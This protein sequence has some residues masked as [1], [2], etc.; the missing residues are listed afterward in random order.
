MKQGVLF[1]I[2]ITAL[3]VFTGVQAQNQE[4]VLMTIGDKP[5]Y[6]SEF[7]RILNKNKSNLASQ[8]TDLKESFELFTNFKLKVRE[9]ESQGLDTSAQFKKEL[10]TQRSQLAKPY[11][12]DKQITEDLVREAYER[13]K[14]EV[15]ASHILVGI[16]MDAP[17][18]DTLLAYRKTM[19][20][21]D[22][23]VKGESF[24]A[25]AREVSDDVSAA[26][27]GGDIGY[28]PVLQVVYPF[29]TAVFTQKPGEISMPV[30]TQFGYHLIK[31]TDKQPSKGKLQIATIWKSVNYTT[32]DEEKAKIKEEIQNIYIQLRTGA[33]FGEL[34][35]KYSDDRTMA[36]KGDAGFWIG[37]REREP[38]F[39]EA[40]YAL[41]NPGDLTEPVETSLGWFIIRLLDKKPPET[42][43]EARNGL[44]QKINRSPDRAMKSEQAIVAKLKKEYTYNL[45]Q[46]NLE[47]FY[48]LVDPS[49]FE[50]RWDPNPSLQK[51]G[52][53]FTLSNLTVRQN[54]FAKFLALNQR[55]STVRTIAEFVDEKFGEFSKLKILE[56][57]ELQL[58]RKYP[59][60]RDLYQEFHDGNLLFEITDRMVWSKATLDTTGL[61]DYFAAHQNQYMWPER[62]DAVMIYAKGSNNLQKMV[63]EYRSVMLKKCK[64]G[65]DGTTIQNIL[66]EITGK[67]N[68]NS[69]EIEDKL[70][71]KGDSWII[72]QI[73]WKPGASEIVS[74][75]DT[76]VFV[77]INKVVE[78]RSKKLEDNRGQVTADFQDYLE[79]E[80]VK[81]LRQKFPVKVNQ[82]VLSK[83][84]I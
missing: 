82:D 40:A 74:E 31:V 48:R 66:G 65:C 46:A 69:F 28:F 41:K 29:E 58:D 7:V 47:E 11:L 14:F 18:A 19:A 38:A 3:G 75:Q 42:F 44:Y 81:S 64:G 63:E 20:I 13:G 53:L 52:V 76:K 61:K 34:A 60:F 36:V 32:T 2:A 54:D 55:E 27:N 57:E 21:R 37:P 51:T 71:T 62:L 77:W 35:R 45:N 8:K 25:V 5:V 56:Y 79:K 12:L 22:R 43:E 4:A 15:R 10:A 68:G 67:F 24:E 78:P 83:I 70:Y 1:S 6:A 72:D 26:T 84:K 49:V 73:K 80:W 59:E 33:D 16:K 23:L 9:A 50:G 17:A 30:R 39:D